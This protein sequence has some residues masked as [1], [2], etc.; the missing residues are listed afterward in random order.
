MRKNV[1]DLKLQQADPTKNCLPASVLPNILSD[2]PQQ[3]KAPV[4][5][6]IRNEGKMKSLGQPRATWRVCNHLEEASG[7]AGYR[8]IWRPTSGNQTRKKPVHMYIVN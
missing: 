3:R 5:E 7:T 1:D 4:T 2:I 6:D 8:A